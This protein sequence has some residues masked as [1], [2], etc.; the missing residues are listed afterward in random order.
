[1]PPQCQY[2]TRPAVYH[3]K[4]SNEFVCATHFCKTIERKIR[5][6]VRKYAMFTPQDKIVVGVSGGKDSLVLLYNV[7]LLQR[8]NPSHPQV[9]AL[10]IDE[11]IAGYRSESVAIA[12]QMCQKW[13]VTLH[14]KSFEADFGKKLDDTIAETGRLEVNACT[15][16][17]TVRRRL[18][19]EGARELGADA[20]AI[21]HNLDDVAET[22]LQNI[23][24]NDLQKISMKPPYG[25]P[26][27]I[28]KRLIP[29]VKPLLG[30]PEAEVTRYCYYKQIPIQTTPCPYVEGF[31]ILRA[32][33]QSFLNELEQQSAEVKYNLLK[34]NDQLYAK[35]QENTPQTS[36]KEPSKESM[37]SNKCERCGEFR[38]H[39]RKICYYC[40]LQEKLGI[41]P[42][43]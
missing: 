11:G 13:G 25:N 2:C 43:K 20:L 3:R 15:I 21:G 10:L 9:E 32:K 42:P 33:V 38:G 23:L 26:P 7:L 30:I 1:M 34:L 41:T 29:R 12:Q 8:R 14:I 35:L 31:F 16:C 17:G 40:E 39:R 4:I 28:S 37:G 19:N 22:F 18:L 24:R 36:A 27:F 5:K 6:T